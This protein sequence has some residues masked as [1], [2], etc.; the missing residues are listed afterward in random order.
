MLLQSSNSFIVVLTARIFL[1]CTYGI[2]HSI[3][4]IVNAL[5]FSNYAYFLVPLFSGLRI[6]M[7]LLTANLHFIVIY[8]FSKM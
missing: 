2:F 8:L 7:H 5:L 1:I 6:S 3:G 4:I